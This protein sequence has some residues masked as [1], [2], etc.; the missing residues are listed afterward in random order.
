MIYEVIFSSSLAYGLNFL[1]LRYLDASQTASFT[2]LQPF[3]T[4]LLVWFVHGR[5]PSITL[6]LAGI[7]VLFTALLGRLALNKKSKTKQ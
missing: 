6:A 1:T 2:Y 7:G 5:L 3:I 4:A